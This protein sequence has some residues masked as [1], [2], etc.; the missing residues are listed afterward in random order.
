MSGRSAYVRKK[1]T[2]T[3]LREKDAAQ[4]AA[5]ARAKSLASSEADSHHGMGDYG[6]MPGGGGGGYRQ[7]NTGIPTMNARF[8]KFEQAQ[9]EAAEASAQYRAEMMH[10]PQGFGPQQ[11]GVG[12]GSQ[13]G[14]S[15]DG[16]PPHQQQPQFRGPLEDFAYARARR[17]VVKT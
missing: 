4:T 10:A 13:S 8:L 5:R 2:E 17:P 9:R 16:R 3:Q 11:T 7:D 14:S 6:P 12:G 15:V 1:I